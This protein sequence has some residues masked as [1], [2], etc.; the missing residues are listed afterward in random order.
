MRRPAGAARGCAGWAACGSARPPVAA[1]RPARSLD[2][3][4]AAGRRHE[5]LALGSAALQLGD[6]PL[7]I[8]LVGRGD[9]LAHQLL[10]EVRQRPDLQTGVRPQA[11]ERVAEQGSLDAAVDAHGP[12]A[13][14]SVHADVPLAREPGGRH[15]RGGDDHGDGRDHHRGNGPPDPA[16][17][18]PTI[19]RSGVR[20]RRAPGVL[21]GRDDDLGVDEGLRCGG[22]SAVDGRR[23]LRPVRIGLGVV[24]EADGGQPQAHARLAGRSDDDRRGPVVHDGDVGTGVRHV[25]DVG[26]HDRD[27]VGRPALEGQVDQARHRS[28]RVPLGQ[29]AADLR[30]AHDAGEAVGAQHVAVAVPC[31]AHRQIGLHRVHA[32]EGAHEQR[33]PGVDRGLLLRDAAGIDEGLHVGVVVG[34]LR[35]LAIAQQVGARVADVHDGQPI[36]EPV[37]AG[38]RRAHPREV[39]VR[40]DDVGDAVAHLRDRVAERAQHLVRR[41]RVHVEV[42]HGRHRDGAG[43]LPGRMPAHAVGHEQQRGAGVAGVLVALAD[44]SDVGPGGVAQDE[45]HGALLLDLQRGAPDTQRGAHGQDGRGGDAGAVDP[46]AVR[47]AEVLHDPRPLG[48]VDPRVPAGRVVVIDDEGRVGCA[49]DGDLDV[50]Q[51][52]DRAEQRSLDHDELAALDLLL[53]VH[54]RR[55]RG[56][57]GTGGLALAAGGPGLRGL[58]QVATQGQHGDEHERPQQREES[59]PHEGERQLRHGSAAPEHQLRRADHDRRAVRHLDLRDLL[60]VDEGAVRRVEVAHEDGRPEDD[61]AVVARGARI[62]DADVGVAAAAEAGDGTHQRVGGAADLEPGLARVD[63]DGVL[64]ARRTA[65]RRVPR[66]APGRCRSRARRPGRG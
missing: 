44:E 50:A 64:A 9:A 25:D 29:G 7:G 58:A 8:D 3:P 11:R 46:R 31:L 15:D 12:G 53:L 60:A 30:A 32:V 34:D 28:R 49:T 13:G 62:L 20:L 27:V 51:R 43:E 61:L 10:V 42:G 56:A 57:G 35:Q 37:D 2:G 17:P 23:R 19:A 52:H 16:A 40:G 41:R 24:G 26:D 33:S 18:A 22:R 65:P 48:R 39:G 63:A 1:R 38:D 55:L 59:Q 14:A 4:G 6:D 66:C 21:G 47:R 5:G 36:A 45:G 54:L